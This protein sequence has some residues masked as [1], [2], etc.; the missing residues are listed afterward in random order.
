MTQHATEIRSPSVHFPPPLLFALAIAGGWAIER[1]YP[2]PL[3]SLVPIPV[4]VV[5]GWAL[6]VM[7]FSLMAWGL[8]TFRLARTAVYPNQPARQLVAK[9]PYRF[10]RNPMYV[11]LTIM[12]TGIGL[13]ADNIWMLMILPVVLTVISKFV[14]RREERYLQHAFGASYEDYLKRVRR[15]I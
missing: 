13:L 12:T 9:G 6:I 3:S 11:G 5:T 7:G 4:Q 2:L 14:I 15:W 10:S 8:A 1:K